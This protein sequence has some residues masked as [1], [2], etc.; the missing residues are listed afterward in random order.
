[1]PP[2]PEPN[3]LDEQVKSEI[4]ERLDEADSALQIAV[5]LD[6]DD[7]GENTLKVIAQATIAAAKYLSAV[8]VVARRAIE[9]D[10]L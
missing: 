3:P 4:I 5:E 9:N 6:Q 1:L 10:M 2:T 8:A 7:N